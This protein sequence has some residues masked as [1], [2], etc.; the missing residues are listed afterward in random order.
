MDARQARRGAAQ[1]K[2][3]AFA[4]LIVLVAGFSLA[5]PN[6]FQMTNIM[7]ILQ[8]ASVNG[9][10]AVEK[11]EDAEARAGGSHGNKGEEVALAALEMV[12]LLEQLP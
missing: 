4:S 1:Q 9:V 8:A 7:A 6:F 3:L 12:N 5:S 10:L 2:I 11:F